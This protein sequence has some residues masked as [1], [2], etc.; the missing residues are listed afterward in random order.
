MRQL[1]L[2]GAIFIVSGAA[3]AAASQLSDDELRA[4]VS[5]KTV[6]IDTPLGLPIT[7]SYSANGLMSGSAGLALGAY[8]G[9]TKDR[10]RWHVKNGKLCTKWF[11]WLG[12]DAS[13]MSLRQD[14]GKIYWH[15]DDGQS[16]TA[17]IEPGPPVLAGT[18]ASAL[19]V[20]VEPA[21]PAETKAP[22]PVAREASPARSEAV[23]APAVASGQD[24]RVEQGIGAWRA[25]VTAN[26]VAGTTAPHV[27]MAS[28]TPGHGMSQP[29]AHGSAHMSVD[30][31][32]RDAQPMRLAA[33]VAAIGAMEHR[34]CLD[35]ALSNGRPR[36]IANAG[37]SGLA[38]APSLLAI[39]E[40]QA[41]GGE[42][43]LYD[44]SC[45]TEE[46]A[47]AVLDRLANSSAR[48]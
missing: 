22:P 18:T 28:M 3:D 17:S 45:L 34:W 33:D 26:R 42:L 19:G 46:P 36:E 48:R 29:A 12:A 21:A 47:I 35:N 7:V 2:I 1:A 5:G 25:S 39:A 38:G 40:E 27:V 13:C 4:A 44:A 43:P 11:K 20:P 15:S 23:E 41:Y 10:G 31:F 16:G 37:L 32:E 14:G 9:S 8:L 6:K 24:L 30:P